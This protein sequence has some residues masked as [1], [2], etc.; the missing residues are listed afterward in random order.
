M[1]DERFVIF[2]AILSFIG[3]ISY[4][5][6]TVKGRVKPNRVSW[7]LWAFIPLIAFYAEIK[8]GVGL[9]ALMTFM[10]GF[11]PAIIFISS[12][13]NRKAFWKISSLDIF[14]G[15]LSL[16]G[17][18]LWLVSKN[19]NLA[20]LFSIFAD[21]LAGVP[22]VVKAYHFP[23]T[24]NYPVYLLSGVN[25]LITLMAIKIWNF[26]HFAFPIYIFLLCLLLFLLTKF[27]LGKRLIH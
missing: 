3:H 26:A 11:G 7:L 20:I 15:I 18:L 2:G 25:A 8:Q 17:V 4:I 14:C 16:A 21:F 10:V 9:A 12:F 27:K 6:D 19:G 22:T 13:I 24:E 23:E 5:S 1:I